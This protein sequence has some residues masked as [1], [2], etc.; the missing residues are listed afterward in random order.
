[1]TSWT[2]ETELRNWLVDY[3]VT[4]IGCRPEDIHLDAP[5]NE[6]GV[7]SRDALVLAGE[8][9]ELLGRFVS[10]VDFWQNPTINTLAHGL[11]NPD[12]EPAAGGAQAVGSLHEPIAVIGLG[13]WLPGDHG[14]VRGPDGFWQFL[15]DGRS[16]V[17]QVPEGRWQLFDDGTAETRAVLAR[18]TKWGS[19]LDEVAA[20][21]AEF[22][23]ISPSEADRIDPQQRLLLEVAVEALDH[24]GI[25]AE[26]LQRT[27]TGVFAGAC[28]S[29]YGFLASQDLPRIDA[30]TGTGGALSIIANRLSYFLDARGPSVTIDTACSSSLVAIH[31]ACRSLRIGESD[32]ALAAGV[33]LVL[34]PIITRSFDTAEA[35]SR[36]GAC[37]SFDAGADGFVRG[38]G[39]GVVVLKRLSE[40]VRDGNRILAVVRGSAM[41]QDGRSNGLMAPNP[42][43]QA[44][45]LRAACAD[46]GVEPLEVDYV[47]AHGTGTLL[48]DPIEARG[49]GSVY[50]RGRAPDSPLLIGSVKSNMGHLEAAAGV[51]GFIKATLALQRGRIPG[52]LH[53]DAPN[54][55]IPF[56]EL[57]LK[58][59]AESINWPATGRPR[60]AGV[61]SF[62]FGGTNAHLV[63]EGPPAPTPTPLWAA[64]APVTTLVVSGKTPQ[65]VAVWAGAL[66]DWMEGP[67]VVVPLADIAHTVN[68]HRARQAVFA[69][70]A[71][72]SRDEAVAGL[73][74]LAAGQ[75]AIG[76]V[77]PHEGSCSSGTVF[78]YSGQG[79][80]WAGMGRLLLAD[81]P[82]FA[83]AVDELEPVFVAEL[84]FSLYDVLANAEPV[85]GSVR[86]QSV[87][88]G[89]QLALTALWRSYGIEPDA[90]IGHSMGEVT[91][92]VVSGAL[93]PEEGLRVIAVRSRLMSEL[94]DKGAV[95]LLELDAPAAEALIADFPGVTVSVYS[96]PRQTVVAGPTESVEA[97]IAAARAQNTFARRVNMEVASHTA[98]MDPI[99]PE[100]R[101]QLADLVPGFPTIPV[102]PTTAGREDMPTFDADYW[103]DNLR[104]QVRFSQAVAEAAEQHAVFIEVSPHPLLTHAID[105]TVSQAHHH[106]IGTLQRDAD[107]TVTF[108]TNLDAA[109]TK[110]PPQTGH[111]PEPHPQLPS[112]PWLHTDHWFSTTPK[113][114]V[115]GG[116]PQPGTLLGD[117]ITVFSTPPAQLW[118][119]RL[120]ADG[121][122]Y[123][124]R[125]RLHGV[126]LAPAS[127]L[128]QT[129]LAAAA[130]TGAG[131]VHDIAFLQPLLMDQPR[132]VQV[133]NDGDTVT[134]SSGSDGIGQRW[135]RH[136]SAAVAPAG[137]VPAH[138]PLRAPDRAAAQQFSIIDYLIER[139]VDGPPF[140]WSVQ[141]LSPT[142]EGV[143]IDVKLAAPSA[144]A[145]LDAA[146]HLGSL[147]SSAEGLL[148]PAAAE[149]V[150]LVGEHTD[151]HVV[152]DVRRAGG[153]AGEVVVDI[154]AAAADGSPQLL[155][156]G[157]RYAVLDAA[158]NR[159]NT[160]PTRLAHR[161]T[162][163]P[164]PAESL[165]QQ[166]VS[167][168]VAVIGPDEEANGRVRRVLGEHGNQSATVDDARFVLY[169]AGSRSGADLDAAVQLSADVTAAVKQL[170]ER[171]DQRPATLWVITTGVL[172][173]ADPAALPQSALWGLANVVAAEQP[174]I[175][176]ALVDLEIG[177]QPEDWVPVVARQLSTP[178]KSVLVLRDAEV[179]AP[180]LVALDGPAVRPALRCRPDA[181][182]LVTGGLGALGLATANWLADLGGRRL[183]LAGRTPLPPR[184]QWDSV[185]DPAAAKRIAGIRALEARGVAVEA[186]ALDVAAPGALGAL[187]ERRDSAGAPPIRG[188]VHAAGVT[189]N[190]LLTDVEEASL[191]AVMAPKI[192]G[193]AALHEAF[194]PQDVDF[195]FMTASAATI[196]GV[197][198]QGSYAAGNAYLDALARSRQR[199]GGLTQSIDW[200]AWRGLGF[201]ADAALVLAE[202]QR[203]GSRPV[204]ADE[205]FAAWAHIAT[206][207]VAQAVVIPTADGE[208]PDVEPHAGPG[209]DWSQLSADEVYR[210]VS[211]G[212]CA[213]LAREL[214]VAEHDLPVDRPFTELG[215]NSLMAMSIRREAEQLVGMELSVTMLW[216]HPTVSALAAFLAN[217]IAPQGGSDSLLDGPLTAA[218]SGIGVLDDLF[219]SV[220]AGGQSRGDGL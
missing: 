166:P 20:F 218:D 133:V 149:V 88:V 26:T 101:E 52:N 55:H 30:W 216:N 3:V 38:E 119:A 92:A 187:I 211:D 43:A 81:E 19:F 150:Q 208:R 173:S 142:P 9:S 112:P 162:W 40:A 73:R 184:R 87:I 127:V 17:G 61:S 49:L 2:D 207:D 158:P 163:V 35:M 78:V 76:V 141:S 44:A 157:L 23:D 115:S 84:G 37:R 131:A 63:L 105:D 183:V 95:A 217:K 110:Y 160:D 203:L 34:S 7:G 140:E 28:V 51:V 125:H 204:E 152:L 103:C 202:L 219:D 209:R 181:A 191:R 36:G 97:V 137:P 153:H 174:Q 116:P 124:G 98:M 196:F 128:C 79:S 132:F 5:L 90:V 188:V 50:G 148:I 54:P 197:P 102:I 130:E 69:T 171:H 135:V 145:L 39:C 205:A 10:P 122:P 8:L 4:T 138:L 46:A 212:L 134:V 89:M 206:L 220:E 27:Q 15:A 186:V 159:V 194:P 179:R 129:V 108:H 172:E 14:D 62:G 22:F 80:Q 147:A 71:A 193:A 1:M 24:A 83:A 136:V 58:V 12:T 32:L 91:A 100:L 180:E 177:A 74:A 117:H 210:E 113:P 65:R 198:G 161:I 143:G 178:S 56:D 86:V 53:F 96:S 94:T 47:E 146:L 29:E 201:G 104:N 93:T 176:G 165:G 192:A 126:E 185:K 6:L 33:N 118:Q 48:G 151:A 16:S 68:H 42:A 167:G 200:A 182:Y 123:P 67:G 59:V 64:G 156:R 213:V 215:L 25:P 66:A 214:R 195:F 189:D 144:V 11:L 99:L 169:L 41:N 111:L 70:V 85:E 109:H 60:R 190:R 114:A 75:S 175:W 170:T 107:D 21:D 18:T 57:R 168:T 199:A 155:I 106:S 120:S 45:V 82:V 164:R 72:R 31:L 121:K 139:G 13:C 77:G 154:V